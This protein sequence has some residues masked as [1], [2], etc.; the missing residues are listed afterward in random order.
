MDRDVAYSVL[1][2]TNKNERTEDAIAK[3]TPASGRAQIVSVSL[4]VFSP[5]HHQLTMKSATRFFWMNMESGA[6]L[7]KITQIQNVSFNAR[8]VIVQVPVLP[9]DVAV[10]LRNLKSKTIF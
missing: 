3:E 7:M 5:L 6:V 2:D 1:P 4:Q 9:G 8:P 10:K